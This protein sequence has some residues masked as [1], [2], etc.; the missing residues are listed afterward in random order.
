MIYATRRKKKMTRVSKISSTQLLCLLILSR[1]VLSV[2]YGA[3]T[4]SGSLQS[5]AVS[6]GLAATVSLILCI[7]TL[8]LGRCGGCELRYGF[9]RASAAI[10]SLYFIYIIT[11]TLTLFT[12][13][14]TE[15]SGLKV[16][17]W[18][19]PVGLLIAGIYG[20]YK[21]IEGIARAGALILFMVI[22]AIILLCLGLVS[23]SSW[24]KLA[25]VGAIKISDIINESIIMIGEQSCI[26]AIIFLYPHVKGSVKASV[27]FWILIVFASIAAM[28]VFIVS[29]LGDYTQTQSFPV[30]TWARLS[31]IGV[32][33]RLDSV[34]MAVWAAGIFA[35][36]SLLLWSLKHSLRY[37]LGRALSKR[38]CLLAV[39]LSGFAAVVV[40]I[41]A[42]Y[43]SGIREA[44]LNGYILAASTVI[45]GAVLPIILLIRRRY[46]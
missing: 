31:S 21:G 10:Y 8:K 37:A 15:T 9:G 34:F 28:A 24:L 2:A 23:S 12:V 26:P 42:A 41:C 19:L 18:I 13:L 4:Q 44:V 1:G 39:S 20:A 32:I 35:R 7:P 11:M 16:S 17:I 40:S 33:Q 14:R 36:L 38:L 6:A 43:N 46:K 29:V 27:S 45:C 5:T 3:F 30:Y 22:A 25:P